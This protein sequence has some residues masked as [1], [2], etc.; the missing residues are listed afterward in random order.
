MRYTDLYTLS[1]NNPVVFW[2]QR[3]TLIDW[4]EPPAEILTQDESGSYQWYKGGMLNTSHLALDYHINNGRGEQAALIYDSPVT[5]TKKMYTFTQLREEVAKFAGVLRNQ[6]VE[7]GDRVIIYMPMIPE[8]VIAMLACARLGAIHSVVFGGFASPELA[9]RIDDARPKVLVSATCGIEFT[10]VIP[11][12]PLVDKAIEQSTHPPEKTIIVQ[13]PQQTC[14]MQS[15]RDVDWNT[16]MQNADPV[17]PVP[18]E[19]TDPLYI[20]YTSGTTG[21][22]KGIVRDNGGH[23]VSMKYSMKAIYN[24]NPGEVYWAASDIG[25]VVGHSYIVYAPLLHGCTTILYEGKPIRTPDPGAFWRVIA[26]YNVSTFFT[27]PTAFRAIKKEDPDAHFKRKY[28]I[29]Y[30]RTLYLAG[31]RL[32]PPTY[33]WLSHI[34]DIP[35]VDHWWQTET[36]WPIVANPMGIEP[37]RVKSGSASLPVPGYKIEI[38]DEKGSAVPLK[39]SGNVAIKL[40]LPP[41][42]LPTLWEDPKRFRDSYLSRYDGYYLTGDGGYIDED[43]YVFIMGRIDD[44]INVAGHRLST[45]EMEEILG[46]HPAVAECAVVGID[47][48]LKGQLPIGL[49]VLKDSVEADLGELEQD[50]IQLI[51]KNIGAVAV[52]KKAMVVKRLPKTRSGKI[53]R[54]TIRRL[55]TEAQIITPPTIDDPAI[56]AEIRTALREHR[57]GQYLNAVLTKE[58]ENAR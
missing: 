31:E 13:R 53:L 9:A 1:V 36:G 25:W 54:K 40:P 44:V 51:R 14:E 11:Y 8:A 48:E 22:P 42:C 20:L 3:A 16:L 46:S 37:C 19:A 47:D 35:I 32:D 27:A 30:L 38:L 50:L 52:F 39:N 26:E 2:R 17:A 34:L 29:S 6:G 18:V 5:D 24:I 4:F 57:V 41:G 56:L 23:A 28:D 21:K 10:N 58:E 33:D 49:V 45:G 15:G 12:K 55:A 43:G 7:K